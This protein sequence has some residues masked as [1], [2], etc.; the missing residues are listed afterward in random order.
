[1]PTYNQDKMLGLLLLSI[2]AHPAI[3]IDTAYV[4]RINAWRAQQEQDLKAPEGWLSVAGLFWLH[5]GKNSIGSDAKSDVRLPVGEAPQ[6]VGTLSL[7][8][9]DVTLRVENDVEVDIP[10]LT[11]RA[12]ELRPSSSQFAHLRIRRAHLSSDAAGHPDLVQVGSVSFRI[13][14][15]GKRIGVRV[16]D[17]N[18]KQRRDFSGLKWYPVDEAYVVQAKFIPYTP[19]KRIPII[20]V[21]GDTSMVPLPGYITFTIQGKQ[22]R[23][24]AQSDENGLFLNFR[25]QTTDETTYPAGRFLYTP[26]PKGGF[27]EVDFN[28]AQN[29]PC[30]FTAFGTC[31]FPPHGNSLPVAIRAGEL[32]Y[33]HG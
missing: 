11:D 8:G 4:D 24:E 13:I 33:H 30:A 5:S 18:C 31:P 21:L 27:V 9:G 14:Q 25:D 22:C 23:L 26:P 19:P 16:F 29:P 7:D 6:H 15:R 12:K 28:K 10:T 2:C 17:P 32:T 3:K 20:N 1:M